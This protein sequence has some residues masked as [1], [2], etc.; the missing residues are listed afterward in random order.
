VH[1][2]VADLRTAIYRARRT[3]VTVHK[4]GVQFQHHGQPTAVRLEVRP[5]KRPA[6]AAAAT[7][8]PDENGAF[9]TP[10]KG[11]RSLAARRFSITLTETPAPVELRGHHSVWT[12]VR[13]RHRTWRLARLPDPGGYILP[14]RCCSLRYDAWFS[15]HW[16]LCP[17][18]FPRPGVFLRRLHRRVRS[19]GE[20]R[21]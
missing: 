8:G 5:L 13:P 20:R 14:G 10:G 15:I 1:E 12:A 16:G 2:L 7:R 21:N 6:R 11:N 17:S 4:D 9:S 19:S 18:L 3:G